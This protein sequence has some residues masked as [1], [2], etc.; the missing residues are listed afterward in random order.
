MSDDLKPC[1]LCGEDMTLPEIC[2]QCETPEPPLAG[3]DR[4]RDAS[5]RLAIVV[6]DLLYEVA[7]RRL[8][9]PRVVYTEETI[10]LSWSG[11]HFL[12]VEL[13]PDGK[14]EWFW[15]VL[16]HDCGGTDEDREDIPVPLVV[17]KVEELFGD[18]GVPC[19]EFVLTLRE[20]RED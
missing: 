1:G 5:M 6:T 3:R 15:A 7:R 16:G 9:L 13:W 10:R 2:D 19:E 17:D 14:G 11:I 4:Q 12:D 18:R 20:E 8:P